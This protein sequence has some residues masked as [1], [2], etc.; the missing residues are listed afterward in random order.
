[1]QVNP[2]PKQKEAHKILQN[3]DIVLYGGAIR[4]GKSFWL[5]I[6]LFT[7]CFKYPKSRWLIIRASYSNI[8][9]TILVSFR[10][11]LSEGFQQY[12]KTWDNNTMTATLFNGS[13]IMFMAESYASDKELNRFRGLEIN[14]AGIDEINEIQEETFNKVIERSGSWNGAGNV[15]VKIL[16]TCNPT[17]GWVKDKFYIPYIEGTLPP[18]WAYIPAKLYDNPHLSKD[19]IESLRQNM[20]RYEYEVFV[21]GNW[22]FQQKRGTEFYKEFNMDKHV[23]SVS[24]NPNLPIW[25][26]IDENVHPYF[27]CQVWQVEGKT[28]KQIDELPMRNPNNTV[29]GM[30]KEIKRRYGNHKGGFVITGDAT[31]QKQDVKLEKGYNLYRLIKNELKEINPQLRVRRSNPSVFT[32]GLFINTIMYNE[33][34]GIKIIIDNSCKETIKD[35]SNVQQGADGTKSKTKKTDANGI[36]YEEYGHMSDCLDYFICSAFATDYEGYQKG[37]NGITYTLGKNNH[38]KHGY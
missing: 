5:L 27:S 25:L 2:T 18:K 15:P 4:G 6:E 3:N 19:Y 10:Q 29:E 7:L 32:R 34:R 9:R 36:R 13:Q 11:L 38:S 20:P 26:S 8:E 22:D 23:G 21:E 16:C 31:S 35:L 14:G 12:I 37:D 24:L 28:A 1:M 30:T 33:H 17:Q